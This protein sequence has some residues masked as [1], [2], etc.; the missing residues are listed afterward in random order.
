MLLPV[1]LALLGTSSVLAQWIPLG[2]PPGLTINPA[3]SFA[4]T[5]SNI[6][7]AVGGMVYRSSDE[8]LHWLPSY[9][10]FNI[11]NV[12][13]LAADS[14]NVIA[15]TKDGDVFLSTNEGAIWT[16][17]SNGLRSVG[18]TALAIAGGNFFVGTAHSLYRSTNGG[19]DWS[20]DNID[21]S[22][23]SITALAADSSYIYAGTPNGL[24]G[25]TNDG[26]AWKRVDS[27]FVD[28][29]VEAIAVKD[30]EIVMAVIGQ[31]YWHIYLSEDH[32]AQWTEIDTSR[33]LG[34]AYGT[35]SIALLGGSIFV[36]NLDAYISFD[37]GEN[38]T[39]SDT[40]LRYGNSGS[41]FEYKGDLF[42]GEAYGGMF[43]STDGGA[44]WKPEN[45]GIA[46]ICGAIAVVG[47]D[48]FASANPGNLSR[49]DGQNWT[50]SDSG[51]SELPS[52][53][54]GHGKLILAATSDIGLFRSTDDGAYW[55]A[56][57][58]GLP[59]TQALGVSPGG[60]AF[61]GSDV[62]MAAGAPYVSSDSG[63]HW[64]EAS[65]GIVSTSPAMA[66]IAVAVN[67]ADIFAGTGDV[68]GNNGGG[69][70]FK[71][72][73]HAVYWTKVDSNLF[74]V[75]AIASAGGDL[76]ASTYGQGM[77][78]S[79]DD[80][81]SWTEVN[82]GLNGPPLISLAVVGNEVFGSNFQGV[83]LTNDGGGEWHRIGID[84]FGLGTNIN[85]LVASN[86]ELYAATDAGVWEWPISDTI[87]AINTIHTSTPSGYRLNQNY[88]NPF[89]PTTMIRYRLPKPGYVSLIV[90]NLLGQKVETLIEENQSAGIHAVVFDA[91][92]LA[93]GMYFYR[94]ISGNFNR[95]KK[96]VL[97]R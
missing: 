5:S 58:S 78:R 26:N 6:F 61:S 88:P 44:N 52:A 94:L 53:I 32:G 96:M 3:S 68:L 77:I 49:Y 76:Y 57:D 20:L 85:D 17:I 83:Y 14:E 8:G 54:V 41:F 55:V 67:G 19:A 74:Y 39:L 12:Q 95:T 43:R 45:N 65:N 92:S 71:S 18:I 11:N 1:G 79:T 15:G 10:G 72:T 56:A 23:T 89:N 60:F 81:A 27:G 36:S 50:Q 84:F 80:G 2:G 28:R 90:Y 24:F 86:G 37:D 13:V 63:A 75:N 73:G 30:S 29:G 9:N 82:N 97:I 7:V 21:S 42:V 4:A 62:F 34:W 38:W 40:L 66:V 22:D 31:P 48:V 64:T 25:G 59:Q 35:S 33:G 93:S 51:I 16:N 47:D 91:S 46:S 87:D 70:I 69:N